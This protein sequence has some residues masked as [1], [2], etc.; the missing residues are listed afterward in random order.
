MIAG[1]AGASGLI[2]D[3][4]ERSVVDSTVCTVG[5]HTRSSVDVVAGVVDGS[6]DLLGLGPVARVRLQALTLEVIA[7]VIRDAF[8][9]AEEIE[10][11]LSVAK[12]A[13]VMKIILRD[14]GAPLAF[15]SGGYPPRVAELIR[16]G[17]ADGLEFAT[18][19]RAGNRTEIIKALP[20]TS[21]DEH[22]AEETRGTPSPEPV[23]DA[24]GKAIV[25]VRA[26]TPDDVVGVAR[27]F[28]RCYG[29][30]V[31]YAPVV[32]Q[33]DRLREL[34]AG[35]KHL[36]TVAV[37]ADG[38]VVGHVATKVRHPG[39]VVG[40]I[41]LFAVDPRYRRYGVAMKIG[42]AH[43]AWLYEA[44]FVGQ[45]TEAV[46]I[47]DRSQKA[48][49]RSGGKEVGVILAAQAGDLQF[50]GF[51]AD[52]GRRKALINFYASFGNTPERAVHVPP[53]YAKITERIYENAGLPRTVV[54]HFE[55][56]PEV[57]QATSEFGVSLRHEAGVGMVV[58]RSFGQDF[59]E[60]LQA[61]VQQFRMNRFELIVVAFPM[62]DPLTAHFAAG[63]HELGLSFCSIMPEYDNGDV[64]W[65]Q[66][67]NNVEVIPDEIQVASE[68]GAYLRDFV[69]DDMQ[70][71]AQRLAVRDRSRAH[72]SRIYE[73]LD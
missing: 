29:Y 69:V 49:V 18:E 14:R 60:A 4:P 67:L 16:L 71:A 15:A 48:A 35:G 44:G 33:P 40:E 42:L 34:V 59:L 45:Y 2:D 31:S 38:T 63:L 70:Q 62:S 32:Y 41:G 26:M 10:V 30:S 11:E 9:D 64:L 3:D 37:A 57:V 51:D 58:V 47:H 27:L 17:F 50:R 8:D 36:G 12:A 55:R 52:D 66:S 46:T 39:A 13:D 56:R 19:G 73:A 22:F 25:E 6:A 61:Q 7:A 1:D 5:I 72:M 21:V 20:Y 43:A 68:F 54:G 23:L 65:L 53:T 28:F 24:E